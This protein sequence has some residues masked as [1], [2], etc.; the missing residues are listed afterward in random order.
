MGLDKFSKKGR[1]LFNPGCVLYRFYYV[2]KVVVLFISRGCVP[3]NRDL[4]GKDV[5]R[6][7]LDAV[8]YLTFVT[9]F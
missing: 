5:N 7:L 2:C 6:K 8:I 4:N 1:F 3:G 9:K